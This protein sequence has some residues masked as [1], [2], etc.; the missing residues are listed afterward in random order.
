M[1]LGQL[2]IEEV[3]STS[4]RRRG[5]GARPATSKHSFATD[6]QRNISSAYFPSASGARRRPAMAGA[7]IGRRLFMED[8]VVNAQR[9]AARKVE[10]QREIDLVATHDAD[11]AGEGLCS[12]GFEEQRAALLALSDMGVSDETWAL[13]ISE[14]RAF[15]RAHRREQ[16]LDPGRP[17]LNHRDRHAP[18]LR[19]VRRGPE[20]EDTSHYGETL[21]QVDCRLTK[22]VA[23]QRTA[24]QPQR[25]RLQPA[26]W[27]ARTSTTITTSALSGRS[28]S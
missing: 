5:N 13:A 28:P 21:W 3:S 17:A 26:E 12:C 20:G 19:E 7:R 9:R 24:G 14:A 23:P 18:E 11:C 2:S 6:A 4:Q 16:G 8:G 1:I 27:P 22:S 10:L 25:G 15:R